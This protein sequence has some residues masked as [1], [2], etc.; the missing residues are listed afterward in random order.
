MRGKNT[1]KNNHNHKSVSPASPVF[2]LSLS[3]YSSETHTQPHWSPLLSPGPHL[4][5]SFPSWSLTC[6]RERR[7]HSSR[8]SAA[9]S[10]PWRLYRAP[11]FL[12]VVFTVGLRQ[13]VT[14]EGREDGLRKQAGERGSRAKAEGRSPGSRGRARRGDL[15]PIEGVKPTR[16]AHAGFSPAHF[17]G[18]VPASI[19]SI[20]CAALTVP[21]LQDRAGGKARGECTEMLGYKLAQG[22]GTGWVWEGAMQ[23]GLV[24]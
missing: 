20:G 13:G 14:R 2:L 4:W 6:F 21:D 16:P 22:W 18:L 17:A 12:K 15:G 3:S 23:L 7:A 11:R 10:F 9:S 1:L 5:A 24:Q 19:L 8:V